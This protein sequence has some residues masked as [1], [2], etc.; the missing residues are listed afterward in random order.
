MG[1]ELIRRATIALQHAAEARTVEFQARHAD[2]ARTTYEHA[3]RSA[4]ARFEAAEFRPSAAARVIA[5]QSVASELLE[6]SDVEQRLIAIE[7]RIA[8]AILSQTDVRDF[9]RFRLAD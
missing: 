2:E 7:A 4:R 9:R 6:L 8:T 1:R 3:V 5:R